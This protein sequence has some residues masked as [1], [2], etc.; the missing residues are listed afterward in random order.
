MN[1]EIAVGVVVDVAATGGTGLAEG[2]RASWVEGMDCIA[3]VGV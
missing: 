1:E 3:G 2:G